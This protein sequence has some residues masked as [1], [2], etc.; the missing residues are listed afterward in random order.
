LR[1]FEVAFGG[2]WAGKDE[3]PLSTDDPLELEAGGTTVRLRGRID[4]VEWEPDERFRII[5]YK[6]GRN[7]A[8]GVFAG[9][10]AL[11]LALYL[12]AAAK[13]LRIDLSRG[14]ASYEFVTRRGNFSSHALSGGELLAQ[15]QMLDRVLD[16]IV[17]GIVTGDF[18]PEP[19]HTCRFCDFKDVCDVRR[20]AV[21][22]RKT[23][24]PRRVSFVELKDVT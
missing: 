11:Q 17:G 9:G 4:R 15:R 5:D 7:R 3:A 12:L 19:G 8:K 24:D 23:T 16:R 22:K 6:S 18:H 10:Q 14:T 20:V 1:Q 2:T 21:A 13:L